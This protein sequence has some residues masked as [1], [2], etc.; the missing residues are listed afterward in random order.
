MKYLLLTV[1]FSALYF[2]A[3][4]QVNL[5]QGLIAYYSF[6]GTF[7]DVSGKGN[8][9]TVNSATLT[10]DRYGNAS[11]ACYFDGIDD[12]VSVPGNAGMNTATAMTVALYFNTE[13]TSLQTLIGK[14]G[15]TDGLG[16]QFQ[17][18]INWSSYPGILYGVNDP[19]NL[20]SQQIGQNS[21][22]INTG[23]TV[24][25]NQ[26]HCLVCTYENGLQKIYLNGLLVQTSTTTFTTLRQCTNSNI[27][28]GSWWSSDLQRFKGKMDDVRIYNRALNQNEV[29]ALCLA[30]LTP[31][32]AAFTATDTVCVNTPVAITNTS[33][34]ATTN[35]WT[36]CTGNLN[37]P[38]VGANFANLN[39]ALTSPVYIDYVQENGLYYGFMTD[40]YTGRLFRV[41]FG[42]SLLNPLP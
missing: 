24:P 18:A 40:N 28:I 36:F 30:N 42:N 25:T 10:T 5:D 12:Y 4:T 38:P 2:H 29:N 33:S 6:N 34:N 22:Y 3:S 14:I 37:A 39:G 27:Q 15:Y 41:E 23:G 20:C 19:A 9:G 21:A 31:V 16:A 8:H 35:Y 26:W 7:N 17:V 11:S 1:L 32:T 13:Q